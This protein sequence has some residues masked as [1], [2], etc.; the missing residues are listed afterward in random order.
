MKKKNT[1]KNKNNIKNY[2]NGEFVR[3]SKESSNGLY[4]KRKPE[5]GRFKGIINKGLAK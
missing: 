3:Y 2:V 5:Y 4:L 1:L